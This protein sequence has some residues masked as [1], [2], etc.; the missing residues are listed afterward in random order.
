VNTVVTTLPDHVRKGVGEALQEAVVDLVDLGLVAK[1]VHWTVV[2]PTFRSVHEQLDE[3]VATARRWA[4]T[5]AERA[6][7]LGVLPDGRRSAL[8]EQSR[9]PQPELGWIPAD[10][11][12]GHLVEVLDGV[13]GRMRARIAAAEA[14]PVSQDLLVQV[15]GALEKSAWM[16][17]ASL[18]EVPPAS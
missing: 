15:T 1:Q 14:D 13:L 6:V 7:T 5:L 10:R 16:W 18:A 3:V 9:V 2:G 8:Q 17:G 11:A 12:V 4:D